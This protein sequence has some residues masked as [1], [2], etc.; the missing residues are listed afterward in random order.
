MLAADAAYA[1]VPL[2]IWAATHDSSP[3]LITGI[4][5]LTFGFTQAAIA[6]MRPVS[7]GS[8]SSSRVRIVHH[9]AQ[10]RPRYLL[11]LLIFRMDW[12]LFAW[13]V[14]YT[15]PKIVTIILEF[16]PAMF[17]L[18]TSTRIWQRLIAARAAPQEE[19]PTQ[20][21]RDIILLMFIAGLGV[22]L[23]V[24]SESGTPTFW[25]T[26]SFLGILLAVVALISH[27]SA[28]LTGILLGRDVK[29]KTG[30][31]EDP[32]QITM[33]GRAAARTILGL[34]FLLAG[35]V[36]GS[37]GTL[38]WVAIGLAT[39]LG[40]VTAAGSWALAHAN[41]LAIEVSQRRSAQINSLFYLAPVGALGLLVWVGDSELERPELFVTGVA[42]V[43]A[44]N[45]VLHLGGRRPGTS[46]WPP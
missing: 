28:V 1:P 40:G 21:S 9:A 19:E 39:L 32:T 2:L 44:V 15:D 18:A 41:H 34:L 46:T 27:S 30:A 10:V 37:W 33:A 45:M 6:Q 31:A 22:S 23:A 38:N 3:W 43:I 14:T 5:Y 7:A 25:E 16:W 29:K 12:A 35:T 20:T 17:A 8:S 11:A 4:W 26:S 36:S 24:F 42:G 13:A